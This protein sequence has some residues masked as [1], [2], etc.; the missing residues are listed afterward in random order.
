MLELLDF[1][2]GFD[3]LVTD[4]VNGD[5]INVLDRFVDDTEKWSESCSS[6]N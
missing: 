2:A 5:L 3:D 1:F 6:N 4:V